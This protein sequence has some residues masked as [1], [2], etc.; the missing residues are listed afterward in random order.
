[1]AK[2]F[3]TNYALTKGI[4]EKE[5]E[6]R[7]YRDESKYAYV[8]GESI[9]Y[10]MAKEAFYNHEDAIKKAEEMRQKKISSLKKQIEKLEK[11]TFKKL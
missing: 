9:G 6:I 4:I 3:I 10:R 7:S 1:M 8:R 2:V 5:A 11:L